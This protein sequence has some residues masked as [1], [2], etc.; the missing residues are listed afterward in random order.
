MKRVGLLFS[1]LLLHSA[2]DAFAQGNEIDAYTLSNPELN[3]TA[4][5]M[6][7]GGAF[8]ALGGDLS[9]IANNPAGLGIYRSSVVSGTLDLSR[10]STS[11]DWSGVSADRNKSRFT[12]S[13]FAFSLYFPTGSDGMRNW[14]FGF[15]YNRL[16]NYQRSYKMANN[17]QT[18]SM[19][20]FAAWRAS[21]AFGYGN[22]ISLR[23]ITLTDNYDPYNNSSLSGNW[24]PI[25]GYES[26][27]FDHFVGRDNDYQS[28]FGGWSDNGQQ[29][30]IDSPTKSTMIVNENGH[31][32]DYNFGLGFNMSNAFFWG[33]SLSV[34]DIDYRY[35][36]F[37]DE[38]FSNSPKNDYLYMEN[39]LNTKGTAV[40][41]NIGAILNLEKIRL[42][43][44]YNSPRYYEMTDYYSA[45]AGT[46]ING[47]DVPKMESE[48]P[49][50]SYSEYSFRTP[51]KWLFSAA[52]VLGQSAVISADYEMMNYKNMQFADRDGGTN[53]DAN[54]Y[55]KE[56]YTW[57][58]TMKLGTEIN[59]NRRFALRA[60]YVMQ[61]SP[62]R[63]SLANNDVEVLPA[64]TISH[65]TVTSKPTNTITAGMGFRFTP[66][67]F[68]DLA[69]LYRINHAHAYAFSNTYNSK[70]ETD[71][72]ASPAKLLTKSTRF[73]L[74]LGY[75]F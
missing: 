66:N 50:K 46:E 42:G 33:L 41:V 55:I 61:T 12:L 19:A 64:G 35:S 30:L 58:H 16:K 44:A 56:D 20:D 27:M 57:S 2:I 8:G 13:N 36:S 72:H 18:Y 38:L 52:L 28:A 39:R 9:V 60:G 67:V 71:V 22:G 47:F 17:G 68:M 74:T 14:S 7:M 59:V 21:N 29:W 10:T 51:D 49:E 3:G 31:M 15:S 6:A 25:L 65:F 73:I 70:K 32:D 4:R 54:D 34:T 24:L 69:W 63:K 5:S 48:T 11:T 26:G 53:F 43:V 62:M 23:D 37:Y 1:I 40:A 75:K 45:W